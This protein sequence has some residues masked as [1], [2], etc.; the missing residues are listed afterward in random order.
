MIQELPADLIQV[1]ATQIDPDAFAEIIVEEFP[2]LIMEML[3]A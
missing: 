1:V 3:S 2:D